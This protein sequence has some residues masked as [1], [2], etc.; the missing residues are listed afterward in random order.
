MPVSVIVK[1]EPPDVSDIEEGKIGL[2]V[3]LARFLIVWLMN[4]CERVGSSE[5]GWTDNEHGASGSGKFLKGKTKP[6]WPRA[7]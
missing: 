2:Y 7:S 6:I 5:T 4:Q 1:G 3:C